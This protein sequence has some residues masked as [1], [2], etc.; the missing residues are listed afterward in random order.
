MDYIYFK[1]ALQLCEQKLKRF[2][3]S[4]AFN[5]AINIANTFSNCLPEEI[6]E[7]RPRKCNYLLRPK[8]L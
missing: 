7:M 2:W 8:L 1:T 3:V 4:P 5:S 6:Y